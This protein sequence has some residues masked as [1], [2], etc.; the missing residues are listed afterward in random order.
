MG[1]EVEMQAAAVI[2]SNQSSCCIFYVLLLR[3]CWCCRVV[4]VSLFV[5]LAIVCAGADEVV[6]W[7]C[8]LLSCRGGAAHP[9]TGPLQRPRK[10]LITYVF[11]A[12]RKVSSLSDHQ[13]RTRSACAYVI[14]YLWGTLKWARTGVCGAAW[15]ESNVH[16]FW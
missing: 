8:T 10:Y 4:V 2:F 16:R 6:Q 13:L 15:H 11:S 7:R 5:F 14:R 9:R 1:K 12:D 3:C